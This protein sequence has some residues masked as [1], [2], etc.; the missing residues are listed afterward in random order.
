MAD[1]VVYPK[2][3]WLLLFLGWLLYGLIAFNNT[4]TAVLYDL[5][6]AAP[7][8]LGLT[9]TQF[10]VSLTATSVAPI[11]LAIFG[12]MMADR[13]GVKRI[14]LLGA[15]VALAGT[16]LRLVSFGFIDFFIYNIMLGIGLGVVFPNLPKIVGLWFPPKQIAIATGLYMTALGLGSGL[17]LAIGPLFPTWRTAMLVMGIVF[18]ASIVIW[19]LF[20]KDRP[21]GYKLGG[22]EIAGVPLKEGLVK[23]ISSKYIWLI[24]VSYCLIAGVSQAYVNGAPLLL[25]EERSVAG[26]AAGQAVALAFL[27]FFAGTVFWVTLAEKLGVTKPIYMF[28]MIAAGVTA[29]LMYQLAPGGGMWIMGVAT[30]FCMGAGHPFIMQV[31]LRLREIGPRYAG[32]ASGLIASLGHLLSFLLLPF[33]FTPIW[34]AFGGLS[35]VFFLAAAMLVGGVLYILVPETGRRARDRWAT[36]EAEPSAPVDK[37]AS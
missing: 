24:A 17:G 36:E 21:K 35:A 18:A 10:Y 37:P 16:M 31:P 12:G 15:I 4:M 23:A 33:M 13:Y 8:G 25:V 7:V 32:S 14:V 26:A 27:G 5:L 2:Y 22:V 19:L 11:V 28:C 30:G 34:D 1:E 29:I 20:A 3:R 9:T 6:E